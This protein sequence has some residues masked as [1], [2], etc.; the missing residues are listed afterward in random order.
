MR[1][2]D[3][4]IPITNGMV[5]WPGDPK[6]NL[7]H[8]SEIKKGD[9]SNI[10]YLEMCVHTGTHID[11]PRHFIDAGKTIESIP[12]DKLIGKALVVAINADVDVITEEVLRSHPKIDDIKKSKKILFHTR[13]SSFWSS[14]SDKF[15]KNYVGIDASGAQYLTGL[16]MDLVGVDYLSVAP[17]TDTLVP[18]QIFL[19]NEVVLLEGIDLTNIV[20]GFYQLY[21]LPLNIPD[22]NGAPARAILMPLHR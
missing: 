14:S 9:E 20:E 17:F 2:F 21:C 13:N 1:I 15:H 18:H 8:I 3:I 6:V 22:C 12:M 10:S 4:S 19:S 7:S 11:A 16:R 5:T